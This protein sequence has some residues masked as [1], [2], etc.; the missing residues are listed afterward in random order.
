MIKR[1][2]FQRL[3]NN[4]TEE[5]TTTK[6]TTRT[7]CDKDDYSD[8]LHSPNTIHFRTSQRLALWNVGKMRTGKERQISCC[9]VD[10]PMM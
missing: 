10:V 2:F 4:H 8:A 5:Q 6:S 1:Q 7:V 9:V 3:P